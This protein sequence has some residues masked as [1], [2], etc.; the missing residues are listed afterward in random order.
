MLNYSLISKP[1]SLGGKI[2]IWLSTLVRKKPTSNILEKQNENTSFIQ[3]SS[4]SIK[5]IIQHRCQC[6]LHNLY[7]HARVHRLSD[8]LFWLFGD[9]WTGW[10]INMKNIRPRIKS[11]RIHHHYDCAPYKINS[12]QTNAT[13]CRDG[14]DSRLRKSLIYLGPGHNPPF[15]RWRAAGV[16][17]KRDDPVDGVSYFHDG[18]GCCCPR[19]T[20]EHK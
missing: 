17:N 8:L 13:A 1:R 7:T 20:L 19:E 9:K 14:G 3:D 15:T 2:N 16:K 4:P 5:R 10:K 6:I 18:F 12:R 11:F